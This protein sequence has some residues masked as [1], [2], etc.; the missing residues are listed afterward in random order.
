MKKTLFFCLLLAA[1][2]C[3]AQEDK[4]VTQKLNEKYSS[5][6]FFDHYPNGLYS[7]SQGKYEGLAYR[8]GTVIVQPDRYTDCSPK[9]TE[10]NKRID[11]IVVTSGNLKGVIDANA[12]VLLPLGNYDEVTYDSKNRL[13]T[14]TVGGKLGLL[15]KDGR[16]LLEPVCENCWLLTYNKESDCILADVTTA[17]G[18]GKR[19]FNRSGKIV[20]DGGPGVIMVSEGVIVF[21]D[22][23][24]WGFIDAATGRILEPPQYTSATAFKNG[25]AKVSKGNRS[26]LVKNPLKGGGVL[27]EIRTSLSSDIDMQIPESK[28]KQENTFAVI[29]ANGS[30]ADTSIQFALADGHTMREYCSKT[31]GI[32]SENILY[33]EDA[34]YNNIVS[35]MNRIANIA[36]VF[37]GEAR[38]LFYFNGMGMSDEHGMKYLAPTDV[39]Q[40]LLASTAFSLE[41]L[42]G[43]LGRLNTE[44]T[45]VII[46]A[47]FNIKGRSGRSAGVAAKSNSTPHSGRMAVLASVSDGE[48]AQPYADKHH[49]AFTYFL[50]KK[51]QESKGMATLAEIAA[52]IRSNT[53]GKPFS[54]TPQL[55]ATSEINPSNT[56]L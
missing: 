46:D 17:T 50:C 23:A 20:Y 13:F 26:F 19:V 53:V 1:A 37:D 42:Y 25:V 48:T 44:Q 43:E 54:Q 12:K 21:Q 31:L 52:Y 38:V 40:G 8:D 3:H 4:A 29:I 16:T 32:P 47:D 55:E 7:I 24:L 9:M 15:D 18:N 10:D 30:Y 34:S 2:F 28:A 14:V 22:D 45:V 49:R 27:S 5:V 39:Q 51:L 41:M 33:Q 36:E 6:C 11:H 56:K 35:V